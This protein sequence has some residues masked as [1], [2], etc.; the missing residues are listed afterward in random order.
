MSHE[1]TPVIAAAITISQNGQTPTLALVKAKVGSKMPLPILV[2]GLQRFKTMSESEIASFSAIPN[3][4]P[5]NAPSSPSDIEQQVENMQKQLISLQ[6]YCQ[7]LEQR[8][9]RLE[10]APQE[11][12]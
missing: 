5:I 9:Q 4:T 2:A 10:N 12:N 11:Q 1:L 3:M 8:L 7:Q 6:E